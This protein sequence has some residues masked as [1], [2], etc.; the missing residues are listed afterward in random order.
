MTEI[1][2]D[3]LGKIGFT[4][5][6]HLVFTHVPMGMVLGALIFRLVSFLPKMK[7]LAK[8]AY[9]CVILGLIGTIPAI[10]AGYL[11]WQHRF[12]GELDVLIILKMLLTLVLIGLLLSVAIKDDPENRR[13]NKITGFYLL[14]GLVVLGMG[15]IGGDLLLR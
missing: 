1:V 15:Y 8:T 9:L 6:V 11:D 13:L 3:F 5:P 2:F 4:H 7:V 12:G 14:A 10:L